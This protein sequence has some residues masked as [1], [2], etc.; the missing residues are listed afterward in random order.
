MGV[1]STSFCP[2]LLFR[3]LIHFF[4]FCGDDSL[5]FTQQ[6]LLGTLLLSPTQ[7][8]LASRGPFVRRALAPHLTFP[9]ASRGEASPQAHLWAAVRTRWPLVEHR[10]GELQS[11]LLMGRGARRPP[12]VEPATAPHTP[13]P[14]SRTA[15]VR[16]PPRTHLGTLGKN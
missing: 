10:H 7:F 9:G 1:L 5:V 8:A 15:W 3:C 14:R 2:L 12:R 6:Q 13:R 16:I 4:F 11:A